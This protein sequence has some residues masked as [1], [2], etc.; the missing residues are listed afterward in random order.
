MSLEESYLVQ[1][2]CLDVY[3]HDYASQFLLE[4]QRQN[5][6]IRLVQAKQIVRPFQS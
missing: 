5:Y 4:I 6:N 2:F 3:H 1:C